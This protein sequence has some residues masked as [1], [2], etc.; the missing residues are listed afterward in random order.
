MKRKLFFK[1]FVLAVIAAFVTVTSCKDYDDDINK[2]EKQISDLKTEMPG[3]ID[4]VKTEMVAAMDAK[5]KTVNDAI[6]DAKAKLT[7]LEAD[8][9]KLKESAATQE[10]IKALEKKIEDAKKEIL[11]KTVAK[12]VYEAFVKKTQDELTALKAELAKKAT[13]AELEA[14]KAEITVELGKLKAAL[15]AMGIRVTTL[16][17]NYAA[18]LAKHD[19]DVTM[20]LN[21]IAALKGELDPRITTLESILKVKDGKSEVIKDIYDKLATQLKLIQ[22]NEQAIKDLAK[23]LQNKYDELVKVDKDL[24]RQITENYNELDG[25]IKLNADE[26]KTL[27]DRMD[28]AEKAINDIKNKIIPA[29]EKKLNNRLLSVYL[30]LDKRVTSMTF[31][32]DY[33]SPDGTPQILVRGLFEWEF[34]KVWSKKDIREGWTIKEEGETYKGITYLKYNVSPSNATLKDFEVVGLLEKTSV[35]VGDMRS[36]EEPLLKVWKEGVS[37]ENGILTVPVLIHKDMYDG[38]G[39]IE[40]NSGRAAMPWQRKNISVALQVRNRNLQADAP[41]YNDED[42]R[43]VVS[44]EYVKAQF[45]LFE[46]RIAKKDAE[47]PEMIGKF[48]PE[49]I[50]YAEIAVAAYNNQHPTIKLWNGKS[51]NGNVADVLNHTINLNDSILGVYRDHFEYTLHAMLG[52]GFDKHKFVFELINL[53]NEGVNQSNRYVT[54]NGETGVIGVKPDNGSVNQAAVGRTPVVLAKAVVGDKVYAVGYIKIIITDN[55]DKNPVGPFNFKLDDFTLNCAAEYEMTDADKVIADMDP[56]FNHPRVK[57]GKD[58]F[59]AEYST[60]QILKEFVKKPANATI[61]MV[62]FTYA[63]YHNT[64]SGQMENYIKATIDNNAPAGKYVVKT[65]L[66]SKGY[67]PNITILWSFEVKLPTNIKLTPNQVFLANGGIVVNPTIYEQGGKTSTAYEALLNNS[68]MHNGNSLYLG[69]LQEGQDCAE[70]VTPYFVFTWAP[71]G[72]TISDNKQQIMKGAQVAAK[73]EQTDNEFYV[74]LNN[75]DHGAAQLGNYKPWSEAAKGLV[76]DKV[77]VE[78]RGYINGAQYNWVTLYPAFDVK[79]TYPVKLVFPN[80]AAVFDQSNQG[81]NKYTLNMYDP[82]RLQDWNGKLLDITT[83]DGRNLIR[84]YEVDYA[85]IPTTTGWPFYHPTGTTWNSPFVINFDNI[86]CSLKPDGT[87]DPSNVT[88]P[89]PQ[90]MRIKMNGAEMGGTTWVGNLLGTTINVP[91]EFVFVWENEST[92]AVQNAFKVAIPVSVKHKWGTV[93]DNLIITVKP[94]SG[95]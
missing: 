68:F 6:A 91:K 94:G 37:L 19:A 31:I 23:D 47:E 29:L 84:H 33:T 36:A 1:F 44:S 45:G 26:I 43:L 90:G 34:D 70:Y 65:T 73:I 85:R 10:Q 22:D 3:K 24:Q 27:K 32:P 56:I 77:K 60:Q 82:N 11:E 76:G 92:G 21:K 80:D 61:D 5:I 16:E 86:T 18:L 81:K 13:K 69:A 8:L 88:Y 57:L 66:V 28:V 14:M 95:N 7:S 71:A 41:E 51:Q 46:G 40:S 67:R 87:I 39:M 62:H 63:T 53:P 20:L 74:R 12:E 15:D 52:Y 89:I 75:Q 42:E 17:A 50:T 72:Y 79:F 38:E 30:S 55:Y 83:A 93:K 64:Q 35:V 4:A 78:A 49:R 2:L 25:R 58:A 48:F 9:K 54:L 59:F